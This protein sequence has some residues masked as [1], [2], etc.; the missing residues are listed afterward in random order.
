M[1]EVEKSPFHTA[2]SL[3]A[4]FNFPGYEQIVRNRLRAANLRSRRA[5]PS[6]VH[7]EEHIEERL[8]LAVR[9]DDRD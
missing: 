6:E 8:G 4:V 2:A 1:A 9:N 3:K 7:K 5:I